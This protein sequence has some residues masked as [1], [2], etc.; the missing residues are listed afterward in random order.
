VADAAPDCGM[1]KRLQRPQGELTWDDIG[2]AT[3]DTVLVLL[4]GF[5][6]DRALWREQS[7]AR[8]VALAQVRLIIPD[9]PGFGASAPLQTPGMDAYADKVAALLDE[10]G[11]QRAV[12]AGLSMG[13]YVAFAFWRRHRARAR[14]LILIDTKASADTDA[15]KAKRRELIATVTAHG[16]EPIV[17]GLLSGQLGKTTRAM[18]PA[19]VAF[20]TDMLRRA[21]AAGVIDAANAMLMRDDSTPTL[22]TIDVPVLVI[23]GDEDVLTPTSDA[24]AM[25]SVIQG[26]RLVTIPNAGHLAPLEQPVTVNAAIAEFLDVT[27]AV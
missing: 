13:G 23:V 5:P 4:H 18:A 27:S 20:V 17:D 7:A 14:S 11:V 26:A 1:E 25:S 8:D 2:P 15:A 12:I 24:I 3:S 6:H 10:L 19:L 16:V 21:P 9:L 22:E